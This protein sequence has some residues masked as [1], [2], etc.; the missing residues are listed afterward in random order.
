M[1]DRQQDTATAA[2]GEASDG[3]QGLRVW[4]AVGGAD[5]TALFATLIDPKRTF[6]FLSPA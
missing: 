5:G 1:I 6:L 2:V 4:R 3:R